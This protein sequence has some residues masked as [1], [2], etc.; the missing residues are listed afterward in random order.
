MACEEAEKETR[1]W[2][3][4]YL[5][6]LDEVRPYLDSIIGKPQPEKPIIPG[7]PEFER[8]TVLLTKKDEAHKRYRAAWD[9]WLEAKRIHRA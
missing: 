3:R 2:L 4:D 5:D 6:A 9:A 7:S 8:A 1:K